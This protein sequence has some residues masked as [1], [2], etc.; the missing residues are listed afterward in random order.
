MGHE[1]C[2][3]TLIEVIRSNLTFDV[4][5]SSTPFVLTPEISKV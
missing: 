5:D 4:V 2:S 1:T 3:K